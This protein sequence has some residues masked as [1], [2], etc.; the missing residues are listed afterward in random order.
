MATLNTFW[1]WLS[2]LALGAF[3]GLNP[4]MGWLFAVA[5]GLAGAAAAGGRRGPGADR[6]RPRPG[7]RP[8]RR[9]GRHAWARHPAAAA[10]GAGRGGAARLRR[11]QGRHPLPPPALGRH[12]GQDRGSWC[13]GRS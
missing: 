13:S 2:L 5:L 10:P 3:H 9:C 4:A 1:P 12:A 11:L 7:H 6:P 8:R